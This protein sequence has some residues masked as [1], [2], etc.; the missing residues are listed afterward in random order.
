MAEVSHPR[1]I[2]VGMTKAG[3]MTS[4]RLDPATET[5]SRDFIL[6]VLGA[7]EF[8]L[9]EGG[10][11]GTRTWSAQEE[12]RSGR[13]LANYHS[14]SIATPYA[15]DGGGGPIIVKTKSRYLPGRAPGSQGQMPGQVPAKRVVVPSGSFEMHF[16]TNRGRMISVQGKEIQDTSVADAKVSHG[17]TSLM[18]NFLSG[19]ALS[20]TEA[21]GLRQLA[22]T[23]EAHGVR[24][25]LYN[26]PS[27]LE[28]QTSIQ[29]SAL[30][31][32]TEDS[33]V[34]QLQS[35]EAS[36]ERSD[37]TGLYLKFK[38]LIYLHPETSERLGKLLGAASS[39]GP[40]FEILAKALGAVGD[41]DAQTALIAAMQARADD[42]PALAN[43][44]PTLASVPLPTPEAEE[45]LRH[46]AATSQDANI[47]TTA[48][49]ALG[50]MAHNLAREPRTRS[51]RL[52][53]VLIQLEESS[54]SEDQTVATILAL[55]NT[56]SL[57][58]LPLL[59]KV[60]ASPVAR[61][62]ATAMD[63]LRSIPSPSVD[64]LLQHGLRDSEDAVRLEA[65]YALGFRK[66]TSTAFAAQQKA[67]L[68]E[69]SDRV[70]VSLLTNLWSARS[71]FNMAQKLVQEAAETDSSEYV[72]K[73]AQTL[74]LQSANR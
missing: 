26:A 8:V 35:V 10:Q 59:E 72:R 56:E 18:M 68:V 51:A 14:A 53:K 37:Q 45:W 38:A 73:T 52:V 6:A 19:R 11:N 25:A 66:M 65:A 63:A 48:I 70:R 21:A 71:R 43:L 22:A 34:R 30:G 3:R 49:L 16:D 31:S 69:K 36:G 39:K 54:K 58:A 42:W 61:L 32:E 15:S 9:P 12:D 28:V 4:I 23:L 47:A 24:F 60:A 62:R 64:S 27:P 20:S 44:I 5:F 17:E 33:L 74:L 2:L 7:T 29:R 55:G 46:L 13:Y 1:G 41:A 50:S 57:Q 40:T 67:L